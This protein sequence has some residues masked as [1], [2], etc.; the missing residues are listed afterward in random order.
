MAE[1]LQGIAEGFGNRLR[2][3]RNRLGLTQAELGQVAGI[4]RL[5][6]SQYEAETRVPN[7][8][9]LSEIG[10]AGV[11]LHY[12]LFG[13]SKAGNPLSETEIRSVEQ[14]AFNLVEDYVKLRCRGELSAEGRFVLFELLRAQLIGAS[15]G[16]QH[17]VLDIVGLRAQNK[18]HG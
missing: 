11:D 8:R 13:K 2:E 3:E 6:Q 15:Q 9:Y 14:E 7:I 4:Q 16:G 10:A 17:E 18:H 1:K 12:I 5:A